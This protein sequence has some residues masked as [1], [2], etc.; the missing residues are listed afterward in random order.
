MS[1][2]NLTSGQLRRAADIQDQIASLQ[3]ELEAVL[4]GAVPAARRGPGRPPGR[5]PGRTMSA[6]GR[7][8]I[9]AAQR[10]RWAK[11]HA[12]QG[13]S[14]AK[15][16]GQ[17]RRKMSAAA[18]ARLAAIAKARWQKAKASGRSKL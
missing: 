13:K 8:R 1:I 15:P 16:A 9:A 4:G 3:R 14:S 12:Q 11:V 5:P 2:D 7:A 10:A 6:A 18:R 17:G